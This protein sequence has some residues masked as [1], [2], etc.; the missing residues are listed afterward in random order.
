MVKRSEIFFVHQDF[1]KQYENI[2]LRGQD[3]GSTEVERKNAAERLTALTNIVNQC[4]IRRTN[5][6][7]TKY[8][9]VKFEMVICVEM[10]PLQKA[11]YKSF[12]ASDSIKKNVL[13]KAEVKASLTALS[14]I[15]SLKKLCNHPDLIYDKIME[16]A[17]GFENAAKILPSNYSVKYVHSH[18][19]FTC[20]E[21]NF[22]N[23]HFIEN[24]G[25]NSEVKSCC[26]M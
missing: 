8:L 25:Q 17:D 19:T 7:L 20:D 5:Q 3:A 6:I 23:F 14:N 4:L 21:F 15:T 22:D 9:P 16:R 1:K 12:I 26:S 24:Y 11:L 13:N 2:I 10:T 18:S